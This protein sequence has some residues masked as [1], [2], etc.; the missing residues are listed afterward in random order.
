MDLK[1]VLEEFGLNSKEAELYLVLLKSNHSTAAELSKKT[2]ILR[3]SV[4]DIL[5]KMLSRGIISESISD[6]T[7]VFHAADPKV[8]LQMLENKRKLLSEA[9]PEFAEIMQDSKSSQKVQTFVGYK[10]LKSIWDD[11]L[12]V[13]K[14][15]Y[16]IIDYDVFGKLFKE[17]FIQNF[18]AKR[19]E[20][21]FWH[22]VIFT[23]KT[24]PKI[25]EKS[26]PARLREVRYLLS[27]NGFKSTIF[28]Y[29]EK[30]GFF[31]TGVLPTA[32]LI[33]NKEAVASI[34]SIFKLLWE[35]STKA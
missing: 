22:H 19:V 13:G 3:Q 32:I 23:S 33:E 16:F 27:L 4:Y 10:G 18:I 6:N 2:S 24:T 15:T 25:Y 26:E 30:M 5:D 8:L 21:G 17:L 28:F 31:T 1:L 9:M 29:G 34:K 7:K 12:V 20:K 14:D 11:M 35:Q